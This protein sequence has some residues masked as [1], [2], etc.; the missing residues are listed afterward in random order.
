MISNPILKT[1]V[2]NSENFES[3]ALKVVS[4]E[5]ELDSIPIIL[6]QKNNESKDRKKYLKKNYKAI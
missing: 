4:M 3:L 6:L 5:R 2:M 1:M